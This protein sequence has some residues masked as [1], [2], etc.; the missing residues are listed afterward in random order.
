MSSKKPVV[1]VT[2]GADGFGSAIVDRF[3][4]EGCNVL[5]ID[6]N[7]E[8][9]DTQA[10]KDQNVR[11]IHG[12]VTLRKTWEQTLELAQQEFGRL[13]TVVNNAA[14]CY[15]PSPVHTLDIS[16]YDKVFNINVKPIFLSVQVIAPYMLECGSGVFVNI[17]STGYTRPR[18][19]FAFY[20]ASKAAVTTATR[21]MA[22]EYA[23]IIRFNC[24]APT[25]G[26]TT[27]LLRS[28]GGDDETA[29]KMKKLLS[30]IPMG[31]VTEPADV[32][33]A[34]WYLASDQSSFITGTLLEVDG[35]RGV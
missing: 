33:N 12:D 30:V 4:S 22:L 26:N 21:T 5:V 14:I 13:D 18:S 8:K 27:M 9:G 31:R 1:I 6:V 16:L 24:I 25:V 19:G 20:N 35:G 17:S 23:P 28:I 34:V 3:S 2:G 11:F 15:D 29:Q 32:S 10:S 7:K